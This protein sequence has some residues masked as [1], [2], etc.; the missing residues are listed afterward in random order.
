M[1][2]A[3]LCTTLEYFV[4]ALKGN[5]KE[6][7]DRTLR[8]PGCDK[9]TLELFLYWACNKAL[10]DFQADIGH[11]PGN[12]RK[13]LVH[14][15]QLRLAKLWILGDACLLSRLQND[16]MRSLG[17]M[18]G[19]ANV[20]VEAIRYAFAESAEGSMLRKALAHELALD[21]INDRYLAGEAENIGAIPGV[22]AATTNVVFTC[23]NNK[24]AHEPEGFTGARGDCW[25]FLVPEEAE[26]GVELDDTSE[27]ER[28][29]EQEDE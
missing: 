27:A 29:L 12:T 6:A 19:S 4:K 25:G 15:N 1:Q 13:D 18:L 26:S 9:E 8:L 3:L 21:Y 10:P 14:A 17:S 28:S 5:F 7:E 16:A 23:Y 11:E 20:S 2:K 24:C 22:F